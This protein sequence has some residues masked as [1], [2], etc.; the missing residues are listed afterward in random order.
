M[1]SEENIIRPRMSVTENE[2]IPNG[3]N[4]KNVNNESKYMNEDK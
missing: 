1:I 3:S 4:D 2:C